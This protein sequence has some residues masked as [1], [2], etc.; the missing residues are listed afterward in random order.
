MFFK[1]VEYTGD[2]TPGEGIDIS[3]SGVISVTGKQDTL[4]FSYDDENKITKIDNHE[5]AGTGQT[6]ELLADY[7]AMYET[8][9]YNY[10]NMF[11]PVHMPITETQR[12][13]AFSTK[14]FTTNP[15]TLGTSVWTDCGISITEPG[16]YKM[17]YICS[18][19]NTQNNST[20]K[21]QIMCALIGEGTESW[22]TFGVVSNT[23][24]TSYYLNNFVNDQRVIPGSSYIATHFGSAD[25]PIVYTHSFEF[26]VTKPSKVVIC[27]VKFPNGSISSASGLWIKSPAYKLWKKGA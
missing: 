26:Q 11:I 12:T 19:V 14:T 2:L 9:N 17:E 18:V 21:P 6:W 10:T 16:F 20:N 15:T 25:L 4:T 1:T 22:S 5:I 8:N 3:E 23:S 27:I 24:T 7:A 13:E